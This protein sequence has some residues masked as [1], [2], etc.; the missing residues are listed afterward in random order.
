MYSS[1]KSSPPL[2][3]FDLVSSKAGHSLRF[4]FQPIQC[5]HPINHSSESFKTFSWSFPDFP[6]R[7]DM[8]ELY[9][10]STTLN[11]VD[12]ILHMT[13]LGLEATDRLGAVSKHTSR[14]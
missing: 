11:V 5:D 4:V 13:T 7:L 2:S 14:L 10:S 8:V 6:F 1:F 3:Y 9:S 12:R